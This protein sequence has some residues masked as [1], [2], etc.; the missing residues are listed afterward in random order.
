MTHRAYPYY[1]RMHSIQIDDQVLAELACRATGFNVT[2]NDVLRRLLS[3]TAP[4]ASE[5][6]VSVIPLVPSTQGKVPAPT[7]IDFLRS[8]RFQRHSQAV[9]RYLV[10]LSWLHA[11]HLE[12]FVDAVLGF[13]RGNR[14]Y[15]AKSERE[16]L[17]GG[18]GVTAKPV[19][20]SPF[21]ALTT[22]DNRTERMILEDLL[23]ALNYSRGDINVVLAELPDSGIRRNHSRDRLLATL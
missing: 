4:A 21:W 13:R 23:R 9:D 10:I 7:L 11:T 8:E 12:K 6:P 18:E 1:T 16:I 22:L 15:F 19:P 14:V 2:P 17:H 3:I 5:P 20:Q